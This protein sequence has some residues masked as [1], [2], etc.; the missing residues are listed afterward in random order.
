MSII[1][2]RLNQ[3]EERIFTEY[4]KFHGKSLSTLLKESLAEKMEEELDAKLLAEAKEYNEKHPET[5]TH[6]QIKQELGL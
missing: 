5:Y 2:V 1:S 4:A 6:E 3:A